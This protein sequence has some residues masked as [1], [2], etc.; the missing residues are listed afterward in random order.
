[1]IRVTFSLLT[2]LLKKILFQVHHTWSCQHDVNFKQIVCKIY[3]QE[4]C[5]NYNYILY[6]LVFEYEK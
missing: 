2:L 4:R 1:M 5:M 6:K 3:L